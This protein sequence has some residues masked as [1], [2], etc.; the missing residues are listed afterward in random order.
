[1][2][3]VRHKNSEFFFVALWSHKRHIRYVWNLRVSCTTDARATH[4]SSEECML[5]YWRLALLRTFQIYP[6]NPGLKEH[7]LGSLSQPVQGRPPQLWDAKLEMFCKYK[8][9]R[10]RKCFEKCIRIV[11][12]LYSLRVCVSKFASDGWLYPIDNDHGDLCCSSPRFDWTLL[13]SMILHWLF[14]SARGKLSETPRSSSEVVTPC[15]DYALIST[16]RVGDENKFRTF[17]MIQ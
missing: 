14:Y 3:Q 11:S 9:S 2:G 5:Q 17:S 12:R 15:V 7:L 1:M 16:T 10:T 4:S 6:L 8:C 13:Q